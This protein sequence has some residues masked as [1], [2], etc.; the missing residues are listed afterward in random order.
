MDLFKNTSKLS[1]IN[2]LSTFKEILANNGDCSS[3]IALKAFNSNDI[4]TALFILDNVDENCSLC[5]QD[6]NCNS[7]L[8]HLVLNCDN[9]ECTKVLKKILGRPDVCQFINL[10]NSDGSTVLHIAVLKKRFDIAD[11]IIDAGADMSV[12]NNDGF[13]VEKEGGSD[14]DGDSDGNTNIF[15][16]NSGVNKRLVLN[17]LINKDPQPTTLGFND[18]E[19]DMGRVENKEDDVDV[20]DTVAEVR[21]LISK[22]ET[23]IQEHEQKPITTAH[24]PAPAPSTS[25]STPA[26]LASTPAPLASTPAP[27]TPAPPTASTPAPVQEPAN[28][29][30]GNVTNENG[31]TG[32]YVDNNDTEIFTNNMIQKIKSLT[33]KANIVNE[34]QQGG[35]TKLMGYRS[36]N[37]ISFKNAEKTKKSSNTNVKE[38]SLTGY[39]LSDSSELVGGNELERMINNRKSEVHEDVLRMILDMLNNG[40]IT[41]NKKPVDANERNARLIK[42]FLYKMVSVKNPQMSGMEKIS[43]IKDMKN[44]EIMDILKKLPDLDKLEKEIQSHNEKRKEEYESKPKESKPKAKESKPKES[45]PKESKPKAKANKKKCVTTESDETT[46]SDNTTDATDTTDSDNTTD[47]TTD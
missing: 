28:N 42:S 30:D 43:L 13:V 37:V 2:N 32:G 19:T 21:S 23:K 11:L 26:P 22:L 3:K 38:N 17:I 8:H 24:P 34:I 15:H 25:A 12:A 35:N 4:K 18:T 1:T 7:V 9:D 40:T 45:K 46:D 33:E 39:F 14:S 47:A 20:A 6:D 27:T 16:P 10:Q 31:T 41:Q 5:E 29:G 44:D 36:L